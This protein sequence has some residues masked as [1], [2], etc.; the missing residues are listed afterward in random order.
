ME[1]LLPRLPRL[2][3]AIMAPLCLT[4]LYLCL[5]GAEFFY[6]KSQKQE[7]V[8][9]SQL[10]QIRQQM[11][12]MQHIVSEALAVQ[13]VDRI[14]QEVSLAAT[15]LD[16]M[17]MVLVDPASNIR[18]ANHL[19]WQGSRASQVIDGYDV[20]WHQQTVTADKPWVQ[21]NPQ[22][23]SIQAYYP[24]S[25]KGIPRYGDI[26][27]I[28]LEYDLSGAY[29]R[30]VGQ[31]QQRFMQ[32]WGGGAI[33]ILLFLL[34]F[35]YVGVRPLRQLLRLARRANVDELGQ[36]ITLASSEVARLQDYLHATEQRLQRALKQLRDSEQRWLFAVEGS[37][38]G[39]WDWQ[40]STGELFLSDRW[41][42]MLGYGAMEVKNEYSAWEGR[43]HPEDREQVISRLQAYLNGETEVYESRHRLMHRQGHYIWVLDRGMVVEWQ[44]DGRP[45]RV[46]GSQ[47]DVSEDVRN[48][49]AIA[50]QANHD[51]LTN[52]ANRRA[53]MDALYEFQQSGGTGL[54]R[55]GALLLIDLDNFKLINDALGHHHGDRLLIQV[56]ARLSGFFN[57]NAL[58]SRLGGDEFAIMVL[59]LAPDEAQASH[60]AL[61]LGA[62]LRQLLARSFQL[63]DQQINVSASVGICLFDNRHTHEPS[64]LLRRADMAMY[65]A[66]DSGRNGCALYDDALEDKAT[67]NL[68]LQNELRHAI[69]REQLSLVFQPIY[70]R[71]GELVCCE[72]LCRWYHPERGPISPAKFIPVAEDCGLILNIG[73][74]VLLEVCRTI[75]AMEAKG[76]PM[77][78]VAVNI[79]A[80]H[81]NQSDFVERLIALLKAQQVSPKQIELELTEYALLS[82][83]NVISE[84]M[85]HLRRAG[86]SIAIDDF[87]TG[88][89][90]L[91]YLQSLPLSRLKLDA[92]FVGRIGTEAGDAIVRAIV[93]MSHS[94][95]LQV[96]AEG[97][98]TEAQQNYLTVLECDFFQGYLLGKPMSASLLVA[99]ELDTRT[100]ASA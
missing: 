49:Q 73:Q 78:A 82:N 43:L 60:Q 41:K 3:L 94:L 39:I 21:V 91:S 50:H 1:T 48:Q 33:F 81:F 54:P 24:V 32:I 79:S 14:S 75:K 86:F 64:Q 36:P 62:E 34:V 76:T 16:L 20:L 15:D 10:A 67:E 27:L 31:L 13:D 47:R 22:R 8:A 98:E 11:F 84:R 74:W 51:A 68:W 72:A 17:V 7:Q 61:Q 96:V 85:Q 9:E 19:V 71:D 93:D 38:T 35:H 83:L 42:E 95:N 29:S 45:A 4:L 55:M 89:S 69:E 66:K 5:V 18:Y 63:S 30:A 88:Y 100:G 37:Q 99:D 59:D 56:A 12:R 80:R 97:V 87:G 44:P 2:S 28:Y 23:L 90:S 53:V 26:N 65:E 92:A 70:S 6:E 58:V 25:H 46:I 57:G 77:P 40:I 52:L